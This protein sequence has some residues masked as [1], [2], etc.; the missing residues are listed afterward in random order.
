M[1]EQIPRILEVRASDF[2]P[3]IWHGYTTLL[4][5]QKKVFI[6]QYLNGIYR[7]SITLYTV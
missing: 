7:C 1:N 3:V 2:E 5:T 6:D 4:K